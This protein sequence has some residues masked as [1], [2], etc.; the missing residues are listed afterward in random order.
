MPSANRSSR[1]AL[2]LTAVDDADTAPHTGLHKRSARVDFCKVQALEG[3][4]IINAIQDFLPRPP[5]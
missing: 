2:G 4:P 3:Y 5:V 1:R